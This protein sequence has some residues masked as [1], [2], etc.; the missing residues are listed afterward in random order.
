MGLLRG[1]VSGEEKVHQYK[2]IS[3]CKFAIQELPKDHTVTGCWS[4]AARIHT[5]K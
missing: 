2:N 3:T 1:N 5:F 4:N